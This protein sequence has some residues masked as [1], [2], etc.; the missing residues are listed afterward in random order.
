M[1]YLPEARGHGLGTVMMRLL[2]AEMALAGYRRCYLETTSWMK[3]AQRLY[4]K[5]GFSPLPG[6]LGDTGHHG[7]DAWFDLD[8]ARP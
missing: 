8:L 6:P 7:C 2:L 5:S 3:Q 4:V 1:Y